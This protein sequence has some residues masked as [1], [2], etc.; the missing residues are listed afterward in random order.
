LPDAGSTTRQVTFRPM[1]R[2]SSTLHRQIDVSTATFASIGE[3]D[4][5]W[6]EWSDLAAEQPR[7]A[8]MNSPEWVRAW[9][10]A[11][12][13]LEPVLIT[14]RI[15]GELV[16][17]LHMALWKTGLH[18]FYQPKA[19]P[20][21]AGVTDYQRPLVRADLTAEIL[22]RLLDEA[23]RHFGQR[24]LWWFPNVPQEDPCLPVLRDYFRVRNMP[25][26]EETAQS[27]QS[28]FRG[29]DF[30]AL[31]KS[32]SSSASKATNKRRRRLE[33][34][35]GPVEYWEPETM[36]QALDLLEE[37]IPI[38]DEKWRQQGLPATFDDETKV[39]FRSLIS[40]MWPGQLQFST[41][42]CGGVNL[43]YQMCLQAGG[44]LQGY[45]C[46]YRW[47][48]RNYAPTKIHMFMMIERAVRL[49]LAGYDHLLGDEPYKREWSDDT[50]TVVSLYATGSRLKFDL[51]WFTRLR[52]EI[53]RRANAAL[54][55]LRLKLLRLKGALAGGGSDGAEAAAAASSGD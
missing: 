22:P 10:D 41:I 55:E 38:H 21:G 39:H 34:A 32:W 40:R 45:R 14:A 28:N 24:R 2:T 33:E 4:P 18:D 44:W 29:R 42:R 23:G 50:H 52:P 20:I 26:H 17:L 5:I 36:A 13:R 8:H 48:Y 3:G 7:Y 19:C 31:Q 25:F 46:T 12:P 15:D 1:D 6:R 35:H 16:G 51:Y 11:K 47:D 54:V 53:R 49:G 27:Y 37:F 9:L 30:K 43:S